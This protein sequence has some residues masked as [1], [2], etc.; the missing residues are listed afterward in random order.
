[1]QKEEVNNPGKISENVRHYGEDLIPGL[2][3]QS[4]RN[5]AV[6]QCTKQVYLVK[7]IYFFSFLL[8]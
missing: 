6:L 5:T 1:M 8:F 2:N 7:K 3:N 4:W